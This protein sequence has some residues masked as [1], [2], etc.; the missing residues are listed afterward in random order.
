MCVYI[1]VHIVH[2]YHRPCLMA[3]SEVCVS[4]QAAGASPTSSAV[5]VPRVEPHDKFFQPDEALVVH[6]CEGLAVVVELPQTPGRRLDVHDRPPLEDNLQV[7]CRRKELRVQVRHLLNRSDGGRVEDVD[8]QTD[9][10]PET[11]VSTSA[12]LHD[13][14]GTGKKAVI[15]PLPVEVGGV[16]RLVV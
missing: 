4:C 2:T 12:L 7:P 10:H 3:H 11:G 8:G 6:T 16:Q 13:M 9:L 15:E 1:Q 5:G 14:T